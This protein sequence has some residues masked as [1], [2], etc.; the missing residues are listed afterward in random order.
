MFS[1]LGTEI[2]V[3]AEFSHSRQN[4]YY[5]LQAVYSSMALENGGVRAHLDPPI[6]RKWESGPQDSHR[7]TA[8]AINI[9]AVAATASIIIIIIVA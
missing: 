5:G 6:A 4:W 3:H 8:S 2:S 1:V 9:A 7:I